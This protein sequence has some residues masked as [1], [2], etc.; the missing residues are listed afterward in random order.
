MSTESPPP[1][2]KYELTVKITG[3]THEEIEE[4]LMYAKNGGYQLATDYHQRDECHVIGGKTTMTLVHANPD[5]TPESYTDALRAWADAHRAE[6][7][8]A[9]A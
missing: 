5:A 3:N 2:A 7:K 6:R 4:E 1:I 9:R 8:A